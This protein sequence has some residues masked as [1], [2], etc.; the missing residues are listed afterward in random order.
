MRVKKMTHLLGMAC[1]LLIGVTMA[2]G[3]SAPV[4]A[5]LQGPALAVQA[6]V[7]AADDVP[8]TCIMP[9]R[10]ARDAVS[11]QAIR[12]LLDGRQ[13]A[14][15]MGVRLYPRRTPTTGAPKVLAL[16]VDFSDNVG[17][18]PQSHFQDMLFSDSTY[19]TGSLRDYYDEVSGGLLQIQGDAEGG[20]GWYR[21]PET[22][23]Y[24]VDNQEG[25]G[26][27]PKNSQGLVEDLV[28]VADADVDFSQ[29]DNDG[30]G[31]VDGLIVIYAGDAGDTTQIW[32][33]A[34]AVPTPVLADGVYVYSYCVNPETWNMGVYCHEY[35]HVLGLPD[36][37]DYGYES[38]G[39]GD[40][41]LM[42][43]GGYGNDLQTPTHIC[44]WGKQ[45][46][47]WLTPIDVVTN[48]SGITLSPVETSQQV[49]KIAASSTNTDEYLLVENRKKTGFDAYLP[50]E[51]LAIW[52]ID[53]LMTSNDDEWY[54]GLP[55]DTH[56]HVALEQSDGQW[57][58][59]H[60]NNSGDTGD[61]Y[62]TGGAFT[63]TTTPNSLGYGETAVL[64]Q[65]PSIR[66]SGTDFI[67][68]VDL[69]AAGMTYSISG[70][71]Q[72]ADG[73]ALAGV[74]VEAAGAVGTTDPNGDYTIQDVPSGV[75]DVVPT[76]ENYAFTPASRSIDLQADTA[77]VDFTAS[78]AP[79]SV[80]GAIMLGDQPFKGAKVAAGGKTATTD[81]DGNYVLTGLAPGVQ[82]VRPQLAGYVFTPSV[83][84][85][86]GP[87]DV[88]GLNFTA[89]VATYSVSGL[90]TE[91]ENPLP[92]VAVSA[93][94]TGTY[95]SPDDP[96]APDPVAQSVSD[97]AGIYS[98]AGLVEGTYDLIAVHSDY[99]F[100]MQTESVP[101]NRQAVNFEGTATTAKAIEVSVAGPAGQAGDTATVQQGEA[102]T[103]TVTLK[104]LQDTPVVGD[105]VRFVAVGDS[106]TVPG[107]LRPVTDA[108]GVATATVYASTYILGTTAITAIPVSNSELSGSASV[109]VECTIDIAAAAGPSHV[110]LFAPPV[111]GDPAA[112]L[113]GDPGV[114]RYDAESPTGYEVYLSGNFRFF[115]WQAYWLHAV[116][117]MQFTGT[118]GTLPLQ[119][120]G[121]LTTVTLP[122]GWALMGNPTAESATWD[123]DRIQI[124]RDGVS[125][126]SFADAVD[127]ELVAPYT[128]TWDDAEERY[129][130]LFDPDVIP[131]ASDS[132][133]A[134]GGFWVKSYVAGLAV[135]VEAPA[136]TGPFV[137]S[138]ASP[139]EG[140]W[141][142]ELKARTE[143]NTA[144][145][146][147]IGASSAPICSNGIRAALPPSPG[148]KGTSVALRVVDGDDT[149]SLGGLV[150]ASG[151]DTM[152]F[153]IVLDPNGYQG[154]VALEWGDLR[155]LP[156]DYTI[157]LVDSQTG[158]RVNMRTSTGY[159]LTVTPEA[160]RTLTVVARKGAAGALRLVAAPAQVRSRANGAFSAAISYTLTRDA[161]VSAVVRNA[162]GRVVGS[163]P[164]AFATAGANMLSWGGTGDAGQAL[165]AGRYMVEVSAVSADGER[166]SAV[167]PVS[168]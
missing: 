15:Q 103:V 36:L 35:G 10:D 56:Y 58:L 24:Y 27:Y 78:L 148:G 118:S 147:Y 73:V 141:L 42:A 63:E 119:K 133:P 107:N 28:G 69:G 121:A 77:G 49:L 100:E 41:C 3:A 29:Y 44:G 102:V 130:L 92:G 68:S 61:L 168:K 108:D 128:W 149:E 59:E 51:G 95:T 76:K 132:I 11:P 97:T 65:V 81:V 129:V 151:A 88:T 79:F 50:D 136:G 106:V 12:K 143:L 117:D 21:V 150:R 14:A 32:P 115:P 48:S 39:V 166:T 82:T 71:I 57:D 109:N 137:S 134:Y 93:Y 123:P 25:M 86:A 125:I 167:L 160:E 90:V 139:R 89:A 158:R 30:D 126:G 13:R 6:G 4:M 113:G 154:R 162:A 55:E 144:A 94:E 17:T 34:W 38:A 66:S 67:V 37:Y 74:A 8:I 96:D 145:A 1:L 124:L 60:Y 87:P 155:Q 33:H 164:A 99:S 110:R 127:Q 70:H 114:A 62:Q 16:M 161:D 7:A 2:G 22:Y 83:E 40:W 18:Q 131:G 85:A 80:S 46:M 146:C 54:P 152:R 163:I 104:T 52:H 138:A 26:T 31:Y 157:A 84:V 120:D 159:A 75:V 101:P 142:V 19:S 112:A 105:R 156:R 116:D 91:R 20:G 72:T 53:D 23:A 43:S 165:P 98:V 111:G 153:D 122:F 9:P 64:A 45:E 140:D 5:G 47:G 135:N